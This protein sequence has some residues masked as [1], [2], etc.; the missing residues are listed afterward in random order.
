M[1]KKNMSIW[2]DLNE[3]MLKS[4]RNQKCTEFEIL[5]FFNNLKKIGYQAKSKIK[6]A[7]AFQRRFRQEQISGK[8]DKECLLISNSLIKLNK[9]WNFIK[10]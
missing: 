5:K 2:H 4:L 10:L 6:A 8:I 7:K 3:V 9:Y 1:K